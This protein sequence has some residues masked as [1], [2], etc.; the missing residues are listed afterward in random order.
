MEVAG[1]A[2]KLH[3]KSSHLERPLRYRIEDLRPDGEMEKFQSAAY[4]HFV[5][6]PS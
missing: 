2:S 1:G 4:S 3:L 5:R 6:K